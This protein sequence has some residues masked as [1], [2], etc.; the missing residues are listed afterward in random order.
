MKAN[1]GSVVEEAQ[2]QLEVTRIDNKTLNLQEENE[3]M[4]ANQGSVVEQAQKQLEVTCIDNTS[5]QPA[6]GECFN[7]GE[8]RICRG[9]GSETTR[10]N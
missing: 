4:K 10:G 1:Q 8:P 9:G 7:E 2:K 6:G 3:A 5:T